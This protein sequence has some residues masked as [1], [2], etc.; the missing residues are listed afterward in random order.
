M[1]LDVNDEISGVKF[2]GGVVVLYDTD[3]LPRKNTIKIKGRSSE[4]KIFFVK[5][6]FLGGFT[7]GKCVFGLV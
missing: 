7:I 3:G 2:A 5:C 1:H 4:A 6:S